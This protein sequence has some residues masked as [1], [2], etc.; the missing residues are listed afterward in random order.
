[1]NAS[2]LERGEIVP[3]TD[4]IAS[5]RLAELGEASARTTKPSRFDF[6]E[7][8]R[9]PSPRRHPLQAA[10]WLVKASFGLVSLVAV[11]SITA[12]LPAVNLLALGYL[13]EIQGRVARSGKF[14]SAFYLLPAAAHMAGIVLGI[15]LWL[16]PIRFLAGVARDGWLVAPGGTATWLG[17]AGLVSASLLVT[18]HLALA[19]GCGGSWWR[20][21]RPLRNFRQLRSH[22]RTGGYWRDAHH[23]IVEFVA[24]VRLP[25]LLWLGLIGNVAV[26]IWLSVPAYLFT[27]LNDVTN[28]FQIVGFVAGCVTLTITLLWVPFVVTHVATSGRWQAM[29]ELR[30]VLRLVGQTPFRWALATVVLLAS[31]VVPLLYVALLKNRLPPHNVKWDLTL[32]FLA[33]VVPARILIGWAYHHASQAERPVTTWLWRIWQAANG[34]L[35]CIGV[36]WYVYF[37]YVAANAGELGQRAV[38][39]FHALLAPWPF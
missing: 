9:I 30:A 27:I 37:L 28:R 21:V 20:F 24:S 33:T 14:R 26:Y 29:F 23:A 19:I 5:S 38:W 31:S 17:T 13:M 18:I 25:H 32:V 8:P 3:A 22:L 39:Q 36:G 6:Q 10:T 35:L 12:A 15:S 2:T 16:L 1:M 4:D 11:L 34:C 7:F